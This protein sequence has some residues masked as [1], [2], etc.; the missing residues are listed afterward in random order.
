MKTFKQLKEESALNEAEMDADELADRIADS[1]RGVFPNGWIKSNVPKS[2]ISEGDIAISFGLISDK[3]EL[4]SGIA[5][6]DPMH[7]KFMVHNEGGHYEAVKLSGGLDVNPEKGSYMAMDKMKTPWRKTK[8]DGDK[9]LKAFETFFGRLMK[10]VK[11]NE[12]NIHKRE[13]YSDQYF[14]L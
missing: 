12:E 2:G 9:I 13:N 3:S 1:F 5:D 14:D 8:G 4:S 6:N 11:D 7:H 10:M